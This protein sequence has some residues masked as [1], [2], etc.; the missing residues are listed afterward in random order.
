MCSMRIRSAILALALTGCVGSTDS[1]DV[2]V[3]SAYSKAQ[4]ATIEQ[5]VSAWVPALAKA[6]VPITFSFH[7]Q[8]SA[9]CDRYSAPDGTI[10]IHMSTQ[11]EMIAV[12]GSNDYLGW[13]LR[14]NNSSDEY[15]NVQLIQQLGKRFDQ[16]ITHETGHALQ[17]NHTTEGVMYWAQDAWVPT[18][19]TSTDVNQYMYT[20]GYTDDKQF[21]L[22]H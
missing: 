11:A 6:H 3:D 7:V 9:L 17:L 21:T 2:V 22:Y 1:Y 16:T 15:I 18:L 8:G 13:T 20:Y 19:P 10:C 14:H 4:F 5:S 12:S